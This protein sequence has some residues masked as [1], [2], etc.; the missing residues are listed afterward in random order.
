MELKGL[1]AGFFQRVVNS[2]EPQISKF[3]SHKE[4]RWRVETDVEWA[5]ERWERPTVDHIKDAL[6]R[7][8]KA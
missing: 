5:V 3:G 2:V 4:R 1:G 8:W 6:E 7:A